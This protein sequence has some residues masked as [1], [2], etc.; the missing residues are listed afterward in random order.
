MIIEIGMIGIYAIISLA[1]AVL[2]W[3]P[4]RS[5]GEGYDPLTPEQR[6]K[7]DIRNAVWRNQPDV[8]LSL[9]SEQRYPL[10]DSFLKEVRKSIGQEV[11]DLTEKHLGMKRLETVLG[12]A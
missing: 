9:I 5:K 1:V 8:A 3:Y 10:S 7:A 4:D 11:K 12:S 2:F 6:Y